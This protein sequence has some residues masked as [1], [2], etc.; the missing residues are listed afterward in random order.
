MQSCGSKGF[1]QE[2][3]GLTP[4]TVR[5][6]VIGVPIIPDIMQEVMEVHTKAGIIRTRRPMIIIVKENRVLF[7]LQ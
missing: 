3:I 5:I 7:H 2:D 6:Q 4:V 1:R